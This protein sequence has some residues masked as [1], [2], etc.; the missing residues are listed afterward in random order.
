MKALIIFIAMAAC[1]NPQ[2]LWAEDKKPAA[3]AQSSKLALVLADNSAM[4]SDLSSTAQKT[5]KLFKDLVVKVKETSPDGK[6]YLIESELGTGWITANNVSLDFDRKAALDPFKANADLSWFY[7]RFNQGT[8]Y[9]TMDFKDEEFS[10]DEYRSLLAVA[11]FD[12]VAE[13]KN[14]A[15]AALASTLSTAPETPLAKFILK[16]IKTKEFWYNIKSGSRAF[17]LLLPPD[18]RADKDFLMTVIPNGASIIYEDLAKKIHEDKDIARVTFPL[19]PEA[20]KFSSAAVQDDETLVLLAA[21]Q[22]PLVIEFASARLKDKEDVFKKTAAV[23]AMSVQFA[24]PRLKK[25]IQFM[26]YVCLFRPWAIQYADPTVLDS[27]IPFV[28][29]AEKNPMVVSLASSR[30]RSNIPFLKK[31][32]QVADTRYK[33]AF[34]DTL[35]DKTRHL[36]DSP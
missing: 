27:E 11:Q 18:L 7:D 36:V 8:G 12:T 24:S 16:K 28:K 2:L 25:N 22:N 14:V 29:L 32:Y 10:A 4:Y 35:D 5:G 26:T 34:Y 17:W 19:A 6:F 9:E 23:N 31:I 20:L 33:D 15:Q 21:T 30:L 1:L 13:N 3:S